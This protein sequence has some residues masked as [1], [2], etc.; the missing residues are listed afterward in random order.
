MTTFSLWINGKAVST[1]NTFDVINPADKSVVAACPQASEQDLENAVAAAKE[2]FPAWAEKPWQERSDLMLKL[3][4][5]VEANMVELSELLTKEQGKP[6]NGFAD[7]GAGFE[8]GGTLAWIRA[9]AGLT[10]PVETIQEGDDLTIEV[11]RKPLG[12]VGSI[13]PWNYP[14][15][16][17]IWHIIPAML[18]GNT[19][20]M[21]PSSLTPLTTLRFAELANEILPAGVLNVVSGDGGIGRMITAHEDISKIVFTGSTPTGRH[22][23]KS[24]AGNLKRLTLELG[25]NDAAIVLD[26]VDVAS[27][28]GKIFATAFI[29]NGQTCAAL[30][31]LYVQDGVY[32]AICEGLTEIANSVIT[33]NGMNPDSDFGPLQNPDQLQLVMDLAA[34]AKERGARFLTGGEQTNTNG[35][36]YPITLVADIKDGARLV[37][38]EQFGPILPIIRFSDVEEAIVHANNSPN[39]L[40]GSV[41]SQDIERARE[42]ASRLECGSVWI[43]HHAVIQPHAPFGGIKQSG[44]GV[45]F[46][47]AGLKEFT[48]IQTL[49]VYP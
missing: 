18:A 22:I 40:G 39:G 25:G 13:T 36:Y 28:V 19:V 2:A 8:T 17:G 29:N 9:T 43:N 31:R 24:A 10:L 20:V 38:E 47:E 16:I 48:S 44:F 35:Y 14:L 41:W 26:D 27:A 11:H 46:S 33:G 4:D 45:E 12:V 5:A 6:Q 37:D 49:H 23:M 42:I 32:D 1:A 3:A 15:L 34:D 30:K 7:M 21:K